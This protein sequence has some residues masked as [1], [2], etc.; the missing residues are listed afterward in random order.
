MDEDGKVHLER[1]YP[2]VLAP[3]KEFKII[4][5]AENPEL[6]LLWQRLWKWYRN[7]FVYELLIMSKFHST[8]FH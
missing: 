4:A 7:T 2:S 8:K 3:A 6:N 1:Y 5:E